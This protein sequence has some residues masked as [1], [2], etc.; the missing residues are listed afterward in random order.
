M[1]KRDATAGRRRVAIRNFAF[2]A[3]GV[4]AFFAIFVALLAWITWKFADR[5]SFTPEQLAAMPKPERHPLTAG[6]THQIGE[7]SGEHNFQQA[8]MLDNMGLPPVMERLPQDPMVISP[9]E[10]KGPYGGAWLRYATT[11]PADIGTQIGYRITYE[12]LL[13]WDPMGQKLIA[14]LASRWE[15]SPDGR[16]FTF[17][18]RKGVRWSDGEPFTTADIRFWYD[19][20][21]NNKELT[22]VKPRDFR[23]GSQLEIIDDYAFQINFTEPHGL[24]LQML[25][26]SVDGFAVVSYP[27]HYMK[28]FHVNY[29]DKGKLEELARA[30]GMN[31]WYQ[32]FADKNDWR[33]VD[34]PRLWPW[35]LQAPPPA[36]PVVFVRNPYY[37]KVDPDG[38]Q[39]P[40]IDKV[41]F[42]MLDIETINMRAINGEVGMQ[43]RNLKFDYYP[44][45]MEGRANRQYRVLHWIDSSGGTN[46]IALNLNHRDPA[47]RT[48][49][50]EAKF[51]QAL[52]YAIDR[53]ALNEACYYGIGEPR[54]VA[55][56]PTSPFYDEVYAKAYI[57]YDSARANQMLDK[58]GLTARDADGNRKLPTGAPLMIR[59]EATPAVLSARLIEMV[60][61][62]WTAVG[63]KSEVKISERQLFYKRKAAL[64]H[65]AGVWWGADEQIP[66]IDPRWF[67]PISDESIYGIDYAKYFNTNGKSGSKPPADMQRVLDLNKT[68]RET[69]DEAIQRQ[70]FQQITDL[71]RKNLW[72][73]GT[74]GQVPSIVVV[75]DNF[76]NVPDVAMAGWSFHNPANTA[77]ECYAIDAQ[78]GR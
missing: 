21:L 40:Y 30:K 70:L 72:V 61:A 10:Q 17:Y 69:P 35:V 51:R 11:D 45:F 8:P 62:Q 49:F 67:V 71:N 74:I 22:P 33:N 73:I 41:N 2:R 44:Q 19:D 52:S 34:I 16:R 75:K 25:A 68:I 77:T 78:G 23:T 43:D 1:S 15:V 32:L 7:W 55:P 26:S 39:L 24:F 56:P 3:A 47:T 64:L 42:E 46:N 63:V 9:P 4:V 38:R 59:I 76:R 60:A 50:G 20:V 48:L 27:A 54:Q 18:M 37:W 66:V 36:R 31:Y 12:T 28:N 14:N 5:R 13:R 58:L 6:V 29:T 65:D 53:K 57:E